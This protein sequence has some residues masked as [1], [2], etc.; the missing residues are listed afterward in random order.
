M[1]LSD[2]LGLSYKEQNS[3]NNQNSGYFKKRSL[4]RFG[5]QPGELLNLKVD[6]KTLRSL[7]LPK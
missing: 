1:K 4:N 7:R 2:F 6:A 3:R 5:L